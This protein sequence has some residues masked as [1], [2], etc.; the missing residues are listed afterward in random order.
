VVRS[1]ACA[2]R[3]LADRGDCVD[4]EGWG[5]LRRELAMSKEP[6]AFMSYVRAD[7]AHDA[8]RLTQFCE[9]LASEVR[10]QTGEELPIFQ[11][12]KDIA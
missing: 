1:P 9:R 8:G 3:T 5:N 2:P 4:G 10:M 6:V 12:R 11:D 7:D